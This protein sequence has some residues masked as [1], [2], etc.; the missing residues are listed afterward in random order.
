MPRKG[1]ELSWHDHEV[2]FL[3]GVMARGGREVADAIEA[4]WR[5][6]ARF[7]A[8]TERFDLGVWLDA[9]ASVGV[10]PGD[11]A[12]RERREDEPLPWGHISSG[13]SVAY[14][15]RERAKALEGARTLDCSFAGCTG[16][17]ACDELGVAI[18]LAGSNRD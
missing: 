14:L 2:S 5:S 1:V 12:N 13:V 10:D 7:D 9:F 6:G 15:A 17:D 4:A 3:E 11:I 18:S 16:C 8:W